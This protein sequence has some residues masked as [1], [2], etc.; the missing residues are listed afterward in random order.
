MRPG[1]RWHLRRVKS[2]G[3]HLTNPLD[4]MMNVQSDFVLGT[5]G[6]ASSAHSFAITV[7]SAMHIFHG[8]A[9]A[10]S[11]ARWIVVVEHAIRTRRTS[12]VMRCRSVPSFT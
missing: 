5:A 1:R 7:A 9:I 12:V 11:N 4:S 2:R 8:A 10:A 6:I 3:E